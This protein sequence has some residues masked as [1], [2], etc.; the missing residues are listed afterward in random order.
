M[1]TNFWSYVEQR[2]RNECWPWRGLIKPN[3][4]GKFNNTQ[5]HRVAV[6]ILGA[7]PPPNMVVMHSCDNRSCVNPAHL[8]IGTPKD[9]TDDMIRKGRQKA[10]EDA[11]NV[12]LS[13]SD[14]ATI[15]GAWML[16]VRPSHIAPLFGVGEANVR[17]IIGGLSWVSHAK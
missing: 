12:V 8:S 9:N 6:S 2:S 13:A 15:R 3:G 17:A 14:V 7:A 10:G 11:P 5:A 4:Y 1:D 16:G